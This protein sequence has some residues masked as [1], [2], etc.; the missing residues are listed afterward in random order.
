MPIQFIDKVLENAFKHVDTVE[1]TFLVYHI[2]QFYCARE[3]LILDHQIL[4]AVLTVVV[5]VRRNK[6]GL[7]VLVLYKCFLKVAV[8]V[9][10][11]GSAIF[12]I[13][14]GA[15]YLILY[16]HFLFLL[17]LPGFYQRIRAEVNEDL[18]QASVLLVHF[19]S[20]SCLQPLYQVWID[21]LEESADVEFLGIYQVVLIQSLL[22]DLNQ[23]CLGDVGRAVERC[24]LVKVFHFDVGTVSAADV[25]SA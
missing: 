10:L 22:Q 3:F 8:D 12:I 5:L 17:Y 21:F 9:V 13:V 6:Q 19:E 18:V 24:S 4:D 25:R 2:V 15:E 11:V 7:L 23:L 20:D 1:W 16:F 14:F